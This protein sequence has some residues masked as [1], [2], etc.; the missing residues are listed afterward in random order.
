LVLFL[1]WRRVKRGFMGKLPT[2]KP[3]V[4]LDEV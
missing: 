1:V 3:E 4:T 2:L